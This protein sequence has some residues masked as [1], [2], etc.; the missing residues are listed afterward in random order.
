MFG[1]LAFLYVTLDV[2]LHVAECVIDLI[3]RVP[4]VILVVGR[5]EIGGQH[6]IA[7]PA[8]L[9]TFQDDRA[10][11]IKEHFQFDALGD[12]YGCGHDHSLSV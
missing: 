7:V 11:R 3:Y 6:G 8:L 9:V 4:H 12:A 1:I 5:V 10:G 2:V